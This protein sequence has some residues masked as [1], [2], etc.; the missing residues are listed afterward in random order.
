M[1]LGKQIQRFQ[2]DCRSELSGLNETTESFD[3]MESFMTLRKTL[4]KRLLAFNSFI[5]IL[6][7]KK[8][9]CK[10]CI[11]IQLLENI[12]I[13]GEQTPAK[14]IG[15]RSLIETTETNFGN[16]LIKFLGK[17]EAICKTASAPEWG[18]WGGGRLIDK[19]NPG[20]KISWHCPFKEFYL[21]SDCSTTV[22]Y[23]CG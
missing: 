6:I 12:S 10:H 11:L 22:Y 4:Q 21:H 19:K 15:A 20:S 14:K 3:T 13:K 16:F 5:R 2:W 8:Y 9:I 23:G 17:F 1:T 18:P 7:A